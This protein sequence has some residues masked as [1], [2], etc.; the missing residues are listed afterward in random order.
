MR[1]QQAYERTWYF[2]RPDDYAVLNPAFL[3]DT[4]TKGTYRRV[5][6]T[7]DVPSLRINHVSAEN[8]LLGVW[9]VAA[10][11]SVTSRAHTQKGQVPGNCSK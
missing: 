6:I 3:Q 5:R 8:M 11:S 10:R 4:Q 1:V 9:Q 2:N 7:E